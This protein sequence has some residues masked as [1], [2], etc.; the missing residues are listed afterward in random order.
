MHGVGELDRARRAVAGRA[1]ASL[2]TDN[3]PLTAGLGTVGAAQRATSSPPRCSYSTSKP[4]TQMQALLFTRGGR[5]GVHVEHA[6]WAAEAV[7]ARQK[8]GNTQGGHTRRP[9]TDRE[10]HPPNSADPN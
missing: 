5:D 8:L 3:N 10:V 4:P 9:G 2:A 7:Q 6:R 1:R